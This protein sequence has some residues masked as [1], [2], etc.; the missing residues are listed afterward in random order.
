MPSRMPTAFPLRVVRLSRA[1]WRSLALFAALGFV[2][3]A[4]AGAQQSGGGFVGESRCGNPT[5]HG[6]ALPA[7]VSDPRGWKPWKSARTQWLNRNIDRHSRAF[8]TLQ[9]A[10]SKRIAG[11]MGI[12]ATKS[13]KCTHCH[14]P[15]AK[16]SADTRY[17]QSDGVT[18]E[19]CHGPAETWIKTHVERDWPQRR[20]QFPD[21]YDNN[22]FRLRAEKC[23][24]CHVEI[25]HEIV[26]GG[27]PPLQFEMVAYA[28]IMKHWDDQDEEPAGAFS[29]DP[30]LWI[31]GQVVGLQHAAAMIAHRAGSENYQGLGQFSHFKDQNCYQCH[32]KL[33]ADAVRQAHG[34]YEMVAIGLAAV[35][36]DQRGALS[37]LWQGVTGAVPSSADAAQQKAQALKDFLSGLAGRLAGQRVNK[38]QTVQMLKQI[39]ASG[40]T[41]KSMRRF[42]FSRPP[43]SNVLDVD[44]I[45]IPWWYSTGPVEQTVLAVQAL[46]DPAVGTKCT[47]ID[48]D[49]RTL[50]R[51]ADRF[52]YT[53]DAFDGALGAISRKLF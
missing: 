2:T 45:D 22:N 34:H 47:S 30:T 42:S 49:L 4:P 15:A 18:C 24:S 25:D 31:V 20:A 16:A 13:E 29:V 7:D 14:A 1:G 28:Q 19:H 33:V 48:A 32:H 51:A 39:T 40:Q 37:G 50:V 9:N 52:N 44:N 35:A 21:F 23:A 46:C 11:Y 17:R 27:H 26:A 53:P 3:L 43:R 8:A 5:C 12:E 38:Q 41:L 10:D 6:A 36:P